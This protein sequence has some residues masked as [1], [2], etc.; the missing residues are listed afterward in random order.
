MPNLCIIPARGGSK[1]IPGKN[2]REFHGKPIIAY[3]IAAALDSGVFSTVTVSTDDDLISATAQEYGAVTPFTRPS[4]ISGD[5]VPTFDVIRHAINWHAANGQKF[6][7]VCCVYAT[8]PFLTGAYLRDALAMLQQDETKDFCFS[9]A[10]FVYPIQRAFRIAK[11]GSVGMFFP[12]YFYARSQDLE[13]AFHDAGQFYWGRPEAFLTRDSVLSQKSIPY[14][15]PSEKVVDI[16]TLADW[17]RAE[18][19]FAAQNA[20]RSA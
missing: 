5:N 2:I 13:R 9:A 1:R 14:I 17:R 6:E 18:S 4:E 11:D 3:S 8:A 10:E 12:E 16:D 15:L 7:S 19:M 20:N